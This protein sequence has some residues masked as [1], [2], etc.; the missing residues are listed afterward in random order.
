[1][2]GRGKR[3]ESRPC[4]ASWRK[5]EALP[6]L[7]RSLPVRELVLCFGAEIQAQATLTVAAQVVR[8]DL[9]TE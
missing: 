1:M 7:L 3:L 9:L 4:N 6:L 5:T 8:D 2:A